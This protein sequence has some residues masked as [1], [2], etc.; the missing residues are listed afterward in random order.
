MGHD[1]IQVELQALRARVERLEALHGVS[2][3][4]H[5]T[6]EPQAALQLIVSEAVRLVKASSGSVVLLNPTT[7]CLEIQAASGLPPESMTLRLKMGEGITGTVA[8]KGTAL[9]I[10]DVRLDPRYVEINS[11]VRSE[12]AVPLEVAGETRGVINVDSERVD[13]FTAEDENLLHDL[14]RQAARVIENTWRFEQSRLKAGLFESLIS[15]SQGIN[16]TQG[17]HQTLQVVTREACKL[18]QGKMCSL[19]LLDETGEWLDLAASHGASDA[20]KKK[21]R[22][23]VADSFV[24]VIVRRKKAL[25]LD[26][27]QTSGRYQN[28]ALAWKEG[29]VSLLSVP[30]IYARKAIGALNIY[31]GEVHN[32]SNEEVKILGALAELSGV[33]IEKARLHERTVDLEERLLQN[34][35]LSAIGLL[36]AEVAHEIR[37]PLTVIKMLYHSLDLKFPPADPRSRDTEVIGERLNH[38]NKI[39]EQILLF[40]R[41]AEPSFSEVDVNNL[42]GDLV[43]LI[44]HKL[45]TQRIELLQDLSPEIPLISADATQ[46]GQAFLNLALNAIEAMP[47][48]GKLKITTRHTTPSGGNSGRLDIEFGD[49]GHGMSEDQ[50]KQ[51]FKSLLQTTKKTGTGLG[52]AIV[53]KI[54]ETHGGQVA[55]NSKVGEGT[56]FRLSFP[57]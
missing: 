3:V 29:L 21:P 35:K 31:K 49:S 40:A 23:L 54:I 17:L 16:S 55:V 38:L 13:A 32:F 47:E 22:L 15:V 6:L 9:R 18:M 19:L 46:L 28:A 45:A 10:G 4:I 44:R 57:L 42:I 24:G 5:S 36:A 27:V 14:A 8:R 48:G 56:V 26:N 7:G 39:V 34:E 2:E 50:Q 37:N 33:A 53:G 41:N 12:L 51:A 1:P 20:Y 43:L 52:L 25:Q 11:N 30:M